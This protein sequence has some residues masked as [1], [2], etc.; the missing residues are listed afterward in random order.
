[1]KK[2]KN[3]EIEISISTY[4]KLIPKNIIKSKKQTDMC[5]ICTLKKT[6]EKKKEE[7]K[8][9]KKD[10]PESFEKNIKIINTH[11]KFYMHQNEEYK[12]DIKEIKEDSCVIIIDYKENIKIGGGPIET[13][14]CF[15]EKKP[16]SVLGFALVFKENGIIKYEYHDFL[17]QILSHDSLFSGE[18]LISLLKSNRFKKINNIKVWTDNGNHF[19]SYEFLYYLFKEVPKFIKGTIKYNRFVECHGKSIVDGH[20]GVLSRLLKQK[21]TEKYINDINDLKSIFEDE[22]A[23]KNLYS[24][25]SEENFSQKTFFYIYERKTRPRKNLLEVKDLRINL[26]FYMI[27]NVLYSSP[28]TFN[29]ICQYSKV[30]YY[31]KHSDDTRETKLSESFS[32]AVGQVV[33]VGKVT[34][35]CILNRV[36][37]LSKT[38]TFFNN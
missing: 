16:I 34:S 9:N 21:E 24:S 31:L 1:M 32:S 30:K 23:R 37:S 29:D 3:N 27:N 6:L 12:K 2:L 17:S 15:Y 33:E 4:Y 22:E 36:H 14:N 8:K 26:S 35:R 18:C 10:L 13:N 28:L 7:Y 20:F 19:R 38:T 11:Q 25:S 5:N